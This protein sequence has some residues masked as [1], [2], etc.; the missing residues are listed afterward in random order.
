VCALLALLVFAA[1][2]HA[3]VGEQLV[4]RCTHGE[5]LKGFSQK[6]YSEALHIVANEAELEEYSPCGQLIHQA[7]LEALGIHAGGATGAGG[8][9]GAPGAT[10]AGTGTGAGLTPLPVGQ[11]EQQALERA[12]S[13]PPPAL[14]LGGQVV[15][16][17]VL[18]ADVASAAS[19]LPTPVQ[20]V[21]GFIVACGVLA[22][23]LTVGRRFRGRRSR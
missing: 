15:R 16:P 3:G 10:G 13:Q 4:Q 17:G 1:G 6:D 23:A 8:L 14:S 20:V 9:A 7:E 5:S 18:H 12:Q 11:A 2:A 19:D 22:A 21:L